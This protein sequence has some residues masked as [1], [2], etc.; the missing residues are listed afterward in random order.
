[1]SDTYNYYKV[2][3]DI[4]IKDSLFLTIKDMK[5]AYD[6]HLKL[7][8]FAGI[9]HD[10][11]KFLQERQKAAYELWLE[12]NETCKAKGSTYYLQLWV[13]KNIYPLLIF[14]RNISSL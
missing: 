4:L 13:V 5:A 3:R 14:D 7:S 2:H 6:T 9:D 12:Y 8:D 1:M 11:V 10:H